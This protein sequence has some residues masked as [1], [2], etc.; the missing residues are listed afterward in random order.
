[1]TG[2]PSQSILNNWRKGISRNGKLTMPARI[3]VMKIINHM[4]LLK[5]ILK[6]GRNRQIKRI[7]NFIGH[8]VQDLQRIAISTIKL[9]G[10]QEGEWRELKT[11]E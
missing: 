3:E 9:N 2:K 4:S 7:A 8:S 1:V 5:V 10:L 6:E 11:N